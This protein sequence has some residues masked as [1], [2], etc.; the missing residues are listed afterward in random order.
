MIATGLIARDS[1]GV[2]QTLDLQPYSS[3]SA[4]VVDGYSLYSTTLTKPPSQV[5]LDTEAV[6]NGISYVDDFRPAIKII[7]FPK[8]VSSVSE[9]DIS[10]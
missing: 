7:D 10:G 5:T 8:L 3:P 6:I 4:P 2:K 1:A 9:V